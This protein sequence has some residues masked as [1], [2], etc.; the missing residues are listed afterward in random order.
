MKI[1]LIGITP[2]IDKKKKPARRKHDFYWIKTDLP[3]AVSLAGGLPVML[4][5]FDNYR[6]ASKMI[7]Q[8]DGIII[9]GGYFDI[10]PSLYA[11]KRNKSSGELKKKRTSSEFFVL[12]AA[13][14]RCL[15]VLG[16]CGGEQ[17]INVYYGGTLF[18]DIRQENSSAE[19][20]EQKTHF[21]KTC[22]SVNIIKGTML[23]KA[24]GR[25]TL[26]VNSTHHQAVKDIGK[27]LTVSSISRDGIIESIE[28]EG[29]RF[30]VGV[31]WH[32]EF[33][34]RT[35]AQLNIFRSFVKAARKK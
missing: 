15:P 11:V 13:E 12:K 10:D 25:K 17:L 2:D 19:N 29:A 5:L 24:T 18:Q 27:G 6:S 22:H 14:K 8:M 4:P 7:G 35:K 23:A 28:K 31:Q 26:R 30:I 34:T 3:K 16:I 1:P 32:P 21:S 20:H 33:L 9:S